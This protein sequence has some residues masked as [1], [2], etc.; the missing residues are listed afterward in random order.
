MRWEDVNSI[1]NHEHQIELAE[2]FL[3]GVWNNGSVGR[4]VPQIRD[5]TYN[6][7]FYSVVDR[8]DAMRLI[9]SNPIQ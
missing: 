5:Y 1:G 8:Y 2:E 7:L 6:T 4:F 3:L 9:Y